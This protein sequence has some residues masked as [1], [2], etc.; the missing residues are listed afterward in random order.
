MLLIL[1]MISGVLPDR[2]NDTHLEFFIRL[3]KE[4]ISIEAHKALLTAF[5]KVMQEFSL[6]T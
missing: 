4:N 6:M 1:V 3:S 5:A 2:Q